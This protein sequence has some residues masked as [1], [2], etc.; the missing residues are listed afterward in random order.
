MARTSARG[1]PQDGRGR[2]AQAP[3][4]I[5]ARGWWD[6][7][8]RVK[9]ETSDDNLSIIAAGVAFHWLFALFPALVALVSIYG[10]VADPADV[11]RH[12]GATS[13]LLPGDVQKIIG[14]QLHSL[15][16]SSQT[17]LGVSLLFSVLV[18]L[19]SAT[20]GASAL[21]T[22]LNVV[23][24]EDEKRGFFKTTL[25]SLALTAGLI[26]FVVV[27]L[28]LVAVLPAVMGLIGL[29]AVT[30]TLL[31]WLRWP[32]L[33]A[34][35]ALGLA[36]VYRYAPSR[37]EPKWRWVSWGSVLAT[38][39]WL[40]ASAGFSFY[41]SNFASYNE[42]YGSMGGIIVMLMWLFITAYV[43][44]LGGELNAEL[45]HQTAE[46]TTSGQ[47]QP[48]GQRNAEMADTVGEEKSMPGFIERRTGRR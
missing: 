41:V 25:V 37:D 14:E 36:A 45:E 30:R 12:L 22:G 6:V 4:H 40:V 20:K 5:P 17:T 44:L 8:M 2:T 26:L 35:V 18:A 24:D 10:L 28:A 34:F 3:S 46:D 27:A 16:G 21:M 31:Q 11:E 19:W 7:L 1:A 29:E 42:T 48:M 13:G 32:L 15:T 38:V 47:P 23:Y 39:L 43:I 9:D 33:A